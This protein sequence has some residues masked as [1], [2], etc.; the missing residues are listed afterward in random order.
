MKWAILL[1]GLDISGGA[2]VIFEHALYAYKKG[3][4]I[5][6]VTLE[7]QQEGVASWHRG[8]ENFEYI[9]LDEAEK[10]YYDVAIATEWRSS[11]D[12][13]R[14]NATK[15][16]YFVQSI[17]SRFFADKNSFISYIADRS[18]ELNFNYITEATWIQKHLKKYYNQDC[19]LVLNGI[20]KELF[21][22]DGPL[23][24]EKECGKV[25][26]LVEG[27]INNW[28]KNVPKT[29][30][31]CNKAGVDELWLV[32]CDEVDSYPGVDKVF[33]KI[34]LN[35][36]PEIYRSCDVLVKLSLVEGMF[37][38]PLEMFHCGGTSVVYNING[39]DEYIKDEENALVVD[40][41]DEEGVIRQIQR[42]KED[43][44]LLGVLKRNAV[45]TA[46]RWTDWDDS[47]TVFYSHILND[48]IQ[49]KDAK[50]VLKYKAY[51]GAVAYR[52]IEKILGRIPLENRIPAIVEFVKEKNKKLIIYGAGN[53]C[54][55]TIMLLSLHDIIVECIMV[56]KKEDNP[57]SVLGHRVIEIEEFFSKKDDYIIYISTVKFY[58]EIKSI[59]VDNGFKYIM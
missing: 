31:I 20:D 56:T 39:A 46:N 51:A 34:P 14:I 42:L 45:K 4:H 43:K 32:T 41:G 29:I 9:I 30:E 25:R 16:F 17:E 5:T 33:S 48:V 49:N 57:K 1:Y 22:V 55:S 3:V 12:I 53:Y 27:S 18:Y 59:L 21:C 54:R 11:F 40:S 37:G 10:E 38:P 6:F 26:F 8:T 13:Y 19:S 15:Y 2:H 35:K 36:M 28:L 24:K 23:I 50:E 44:D 7:R 47:S 52:N 58:N